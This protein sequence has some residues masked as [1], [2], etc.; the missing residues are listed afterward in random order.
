MKKLITLLIVVGILI[1]CYFLCYGAD[2]KVIYLND[3]KEIIGVVAPGEIINAKNAE[4]IDIKCEDGRKKYGVNTK[5]VSI[6]SIDEQ[7]IPERVTD[8]FYK[9]DTVTKD[10]Y[11]PVTIEYISGYKIKNIKKEIIGRLTL[12][13]GTTYNIYDMK[14]TKLGTYKAS[15]KLTTTNIKG[16]EYKLIKIGTSYII[17]E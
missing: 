16:K 13:S 10:I 17:K 3:T 2:K 9:I 4:R 6:I 15:I 8:N 14:G 5:E 11:Q 1:I 12:S 7:N